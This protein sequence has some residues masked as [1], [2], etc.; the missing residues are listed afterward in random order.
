M[1]IGTYIKIKKHIQ[2]KLIFSACKQI[3]ST[4]IITVMVVNIESGELH[5]TANSRAPAGPE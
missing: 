3:S 2:L 4:L 1:K 5:K